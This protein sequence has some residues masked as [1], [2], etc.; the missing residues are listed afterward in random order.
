MPFTRVQIRSNRLVFATSLSLASA[1]VL[2]PSHAQSILPTNGVVTSGAA[3]I[4]QSGADLSV[5]QTS[6][7]AIVNWGS[8]SIGQGNGVTFDQP[9]ASSAILNR[10]TGSARSTIAGRAAGQRPSLSRQSERDRHHPDRR[11]SGRRRLRRLDPRDRRQR[12]QQAAI[13]TSVGNGA[14]RGRRQRRLD[15]SGARRFCRAARW[16]GLEFGRR[17]GPARQGRDGLGRAGDAEPDR[18]QFSPGRRPDEHEDGRRPG[19]GRCL[20]QGQRRGRIGAAQG[21]D[22]RAG[23]PQ[24]GQRAG[25]TYRRLGPRERRLDHL[26]RRSRRRRRGQRQ[27]CGL[28]PW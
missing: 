3:S 17:L 19:A 2:A 24:R 23:D 9:S 7:R 6:P 15:S 10:V 14:S 4:R 12:L 25:R 18:R 13:S 26:K 8:F 11:G 1:L 28:G 16:N 21:R 22:G 5:V 27:A 20:R